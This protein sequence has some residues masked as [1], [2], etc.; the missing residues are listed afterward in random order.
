M[1]S[2][3]AFRA[4][5][6]WTFFASIGAVLLRRVRGRGAHASWSLPYEVAVEI[7]KR[8]MANGFN[9]LSLG[10]PA[11]DDAVPRNPVT[12]SRVKLAT[13]M[14][15][16]R[17]AEVHSP[18]G[19]AEDAATFL[20]WHGGGYVSCSP[21]T[22]RE[23]LSAL[24]HVT[25]ARVIAPTYPM[26]PTSPYPAAVDTAV[27]CYRALLASGVSPDRLIVGGDSAGGGLAL[28]MLLKLREAGDP[29]PCAT[30]L[31]SPWVDLEA[32][33]ASV[34]G[35]AQ[36]D[37]LTPQLL[38]AGSRWYAG[39]ESLRNPF[40]SPIHADLRGLPPAIVL[41]GGLELFK[42]END[43]FVQKLQE[44][45][46]PVVHEVAEHAVHVNA[47]LAIVSAEARSAI[48]RV[49]GFVREQ[50][51]AARS[52]LISSAPPAADALSVGSAINSNP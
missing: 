3:L 17:P 35:N 22:H 19:A 40:I 7:V 12:A 13:Q 46:V 48:R 21:R 52:E 47:L 42:S 24:A 15:G 8:F 30:V 28:A 49:G 18:V 51:G 1:L 20:Y 45:G 39:E 25:R 10:R 29:L 37:Y 50:V 4:F 14:V 9:E 26:A 34:Q 36:Y 38:A 27:E 44:A 16:G 6:T 11:S 41:T 43:A 33:G 5:L 23:L 31:L 2:R 32:T